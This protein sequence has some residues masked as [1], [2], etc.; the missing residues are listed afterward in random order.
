V[1]AGDAAS[2][3]KLPSTEQ[4]VAE[5]QR[6]V[7]DPGRGSEPGLL[8]LLVDLLRS[9]LEQWNLESQSRGAGADDAAVARAKR[10]I[11]ELNGRRHRLVEA[12]D[13]A[14]DRALAQ[15]ATAP[16]ATESP[17]MAF[18][19]LSVLVIRAHR[20]ELAASEA[21]EAGGYAARLPVLQRQLADLEQ[22]IDGLVDDVGA[23][24]RRF[25]PYQSLKLY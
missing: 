11:D 15:D 2:V 16:L 6:A 10:A 22:A 19:R 9:N 21:P 5:L 3:E 1:S 23:G 12:I 20:T 7:R 17:G 13:A 8:G 14:F 18:D 25:V 24:R 4:V